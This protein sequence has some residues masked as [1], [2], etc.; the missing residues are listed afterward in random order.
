MLQGVEPT[1]KSVHYKRKAGGRTPVSVANEC[2]CG[3][4][5]RSQILSPQPIKQKSHLYGG[6]FG[7][8]VLQGVEPTKKSVHY[9]RKAGGRTPVSVANECPC[10]R[11]KRSQILSPQP[12]KIRG[13]FT[14]SFFVSAI[15]SNSP[16]T[17][18]FIFIF[19]GRS[20]FRLYVIFL[21]K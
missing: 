11:A 9:K 6:F 16:R 20:L 1:K 19:D 3:R 4:A 10:G 21:Q 8:Y 13:S 7:L 14:S 15:S 12:I 5:K 18:D 17:A 2:P